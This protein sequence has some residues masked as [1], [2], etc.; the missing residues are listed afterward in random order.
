MSLNARMELLFIDSFTLF[1]SAGVD[2][3]GQISHAGSGTS[4]SCSIQFSK[5]V[6]TDAQGRE[7]VSAGKIYTTTSPSVTTSS[8]ITIAGDYVPILD[9]KVLKDD[10]GSHHQVI[11][12]GNALKGQ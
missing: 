6:M 10:T 4:F 5:D 11:T 8:K 9:V 2:E 7:V 12:F 1:A 3:Y